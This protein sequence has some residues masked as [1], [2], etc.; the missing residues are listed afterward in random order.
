MIE[1]LEVNIQ[2]SGHL[3]GRVLF[4]DVDLGPGRVRVR[5]QGR[6]GA[7]YHTLD[8]SKRCPMLA[9]LHHDSQ[10]RRD[11]LGG[12]CSVNGH[13]FCPCFSVLNVHVFDREP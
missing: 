1:L 9:T 2:H 10:V 13:E 6:A 12:N 8:S 7:G 5:T 3:A 11:F 4:C